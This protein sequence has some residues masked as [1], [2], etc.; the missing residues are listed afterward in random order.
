MS[1]IFY[2]IKE[3]Q[4]RLLEAQQAYEVAIER[5]VQGSPQIKHFGR[6]NYLYLAQRRGEKVAYRYVG[7]I[8]NENARKTLESVGRRKEYQALL[9]GIKMDLKEVKRVLRG[10]TV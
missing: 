2:I 5:E 10:Q 8:D 3:E 9:K 6:K 4:K 7:N 1:S